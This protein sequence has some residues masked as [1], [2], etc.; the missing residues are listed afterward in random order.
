MSKHDLETFVWCAQSSL[1]N[2]PRKM[3]SLSSV[4]STE[5]RLSFSTNPTESNVKNSDSWRGKA[6]SQRASG[7]GYLGELREEGNDGH[8]TELEVDEA[9]G[10]VGSK[11]PDSFDRAKDVKISAKDPKTSIS[12]LADETDSMSAS[13][14]VLAKGKTD[15][16]GSFSTSS[17][18]AT[19]EVEATGSLP[20]SYKRTGS[21][22][23]VKA[24]VLVHT[25]GS[26]SPVEFFTSSIDNSTDNERFSSKLMLTEPAILKSDLKEKTIPI[27]FV[28]KKNC[29]TSKLICIISNSVSLKLRLIKST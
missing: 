4:S 14:L 21:D 22:I 15:D 8:P 20:T 6:A 29:S 11:F 2:S 25:L 19:H 23:L 28:E 13:A 1:G 16:A 7:D 27:N 10:K 12:K 9:N 17:L 26:N 18:F 5:L 24:K 3:T